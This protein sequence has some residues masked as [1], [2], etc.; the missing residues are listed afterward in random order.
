MVSWYQNIK[1]P[2]RARA[3]GTTGPFSPRGPGARERGRMRALDFLHPVLVARE[4]P[5]VGGAGGS[6]FDDNLEPSY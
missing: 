6:S 3:T 5:D 1:K 4:G 2:S